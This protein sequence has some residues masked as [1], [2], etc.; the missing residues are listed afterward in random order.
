MRKFL[1][2]ATIAGALAMGA[3]SVGASVQWWTPKQKDC[4]TFDTQDECV[5]FCT[6]NPD[7]CDGDLR[8]VSRSGP[9]RSHC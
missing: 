8:C 4:P 6:A 3:L 5:A 2:A 9:D 7:S 1:A